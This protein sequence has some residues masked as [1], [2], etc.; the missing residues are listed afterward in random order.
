MPTARTRERRAQTTRPGRLACPERPG[1]NRLWSGRADG[2]PVADHRPDPELIRYAPA[3]AARRAAGP[4]A[5]PVRGRPGPGGPLRVG[6]RGASRKS[7]CA[8]APPPPAQTAERR[9]H[10]DLPAG[11]AGRPA[12][13]SSRRPVRRGFG[14]ACPSSLPQTRHVAAFY[15]Q[16]AG[17]TARREH[18]HVCGR[19]R[20]RIRWRRCGD[21]L[22]GPG[23]GGGKR[24][25]STAGVGCMR[26]CMSRSVP[27]SPAV[28]CANTRPRTCGCKNQK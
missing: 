21:S 24:P 27:S 12:G 3:R 26:H 2:R 28:S 25:P 10:K 6:R 14:H 19:W 7:L 20:R 1:P 17:R 22:P 15:T 13:F 18:K 8:R 5:R 23:G 16:A 4:S 11:P 9:A